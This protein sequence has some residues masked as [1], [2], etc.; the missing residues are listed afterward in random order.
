MTPIQIDIDIKAQSSS[1]T[2][3]VGELRQEFKD[4]TKS[5]GETVQG[6]EEYYK[7]LTALANV[8]GYLKDLKKDIIGLDPQ[9]R[10]KAI[11]GAVSGLAGGLT[12]ATGAVALFAGSN[13]DL[14]KIL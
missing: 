14:Q 11:Q 1:A 10:F 6:T 12:A 5:I 2:K 13:D 8:K 3:T 4:L 7:Q 9:E